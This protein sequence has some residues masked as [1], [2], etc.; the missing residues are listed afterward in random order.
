MSENFTG[1]EIIRFVFAEKLTKTQMNGEKIESCLHL[2]GSDNSTPLIMISL[3]SGFKLKSLIVDRKNAG[4]F[5]Y[6]LI[7]R[8]YYCEFLLMIDKT[9]KQFNCEN[10]FGSKID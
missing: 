7:S 8:L 1:T 5:S 2:P 9:K 4:F 6:R 10:N 3:A